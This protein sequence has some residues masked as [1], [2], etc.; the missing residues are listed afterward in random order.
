MTVRFAECRFN[1]FLNSLIFNNEVDAYESWVLFLIFV[2]ILVLVTG[3]VL[4]THK[5]PDPAAHPPAD[6]GRPLA[7]GLHARPSECVL[8][9]A[10]LWLR[11]P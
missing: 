2:S 11:S 1:R 9:A 10:R 6:S 3:V 8:V 4:L 7:V 5:K